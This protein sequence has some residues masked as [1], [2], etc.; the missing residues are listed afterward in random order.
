MITST[1]TDE[2][3]LMRRARRVHSEI[4]SMIND[5]IATRDQH[6]K[7]LDAFSS[8]FSVL[9]KQSISMSATLGALRTLLC[10]EKDAPNSDV[11]NAVAKLISRVGP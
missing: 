3:R 9:E 11:V 8:M 4:D 6:A 5:S 7:R 1:D 2:D 10:V